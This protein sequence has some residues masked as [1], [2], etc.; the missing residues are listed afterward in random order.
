MKNGM[1][2]NIDKLKLNKDFVVVHKITIIF[3]YGSIDKIKG[4]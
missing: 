1:V 2:E 3:C 4:F